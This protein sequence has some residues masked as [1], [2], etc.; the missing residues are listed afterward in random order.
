MKAQH[1]RSVISSAFAAA[2][3]GLV[4]GAPAPAQAQQADDANQVF[5]PDLFG[6][7]EYRM[8]GPFRGGRATAEHGFPDKP[9][10]YLMGSTGGGIWKTTDGG[11]HWVNISDGYFGGGIGEIT[12]APSDEQV[13]YVGTGSVSIRGNVSRGTGVY[14]S[15][16]G[17]RSWEHVG[18][19]DAGQVGR[20]A[21]HPK[22]P[23]VAYV[24][25]LGTP[26][27]KSEQRGVFK[28][29]DGGETWENVLF[30]N[31]STGVV[32]IAMNPERPG[33]VFAAAWPAERDPWTL[34]SG[35]SWNNGGGLYRTTDGGDSWTHLE[36]GLP[37][38]DVMIGKT[39]VTVS[40][41]DTD[42]VWAMI[43]ASDPHGGVYRSDDGG[44]SWTQT[45]SDH[46]LLQ[47]EFY[48]TYI[49]AHPTDPNTVYA[50]NTDM[51]ESVDGGGTFEEVDV[52]HGD[53]HGLWL[54]PKDPER[55]V[56]TNDGG[57]QIS[58]NGG[59]SWS[60]YHNQPTAEFY[61]VEVDSHW[62][63]NL[64]AG[65]QDNSTLRIPS[66]RKQG[67][68]RAQEW[69][70]VGGGESGHVAIQ[71]YGP[72]IVWAGSYGGVIT[73]KN[74]ETGHS[75]NRVAYPQVAVGVPEKEFR[76]RFQ[77]NAP[78][79]VNPHDS[80]EV[81]HAS[82]RLLRTQDGGM[83][84]E[85]ISPDLT[86]DDT[87][88]QGPAAD[89]TVRYDRTGVEIY[90]T[91]FVVTPSKQE[92]GVIWVGTDDGRV[93]LTRQGGGMGN[94]TEITPDGLPQWSTVNSIDVSPHDPSTAYVAAYR[95]RQD[96]FTPYVFKTED[97]GQS[98]TRIADGTR[99]IDPGHPTRVVREDTE[100]DGLLY[101]GTEYG[102]YVSFD[103][104]ANWQELQ[105]NL[106]E[107]PIT[108]L[109]V[110]RGDLVVATQGRSF[111]I[112]DD[113]SPL[114]QVSDQVVQSGVHLYQPSDAIRWLEVSAPGDGSTGP[115]QRPE[116]PPGG[117]VLDYY[118][119]EEATEDD[120][121]RLEV[122]DPDGNVVREYSTAAD[123]PAGAGGFFSSA[124]D[125]S[126]PGEAGHHR[127]TWS[128]RYPGVTEMPDDVQMWGFTG[129]YEA[130][131]GTYRARMIAGGDTT[132][133][134]FDVVKDPNLDNVSD[135]ELRE[136][137]QFARTVRD[138]L[139]SLFS[140]LKQVRGVREQVQ[141]TAEYASRSGGPES[142][143]ESA[144]ELVSVLTG[145]EEELIQPENESG[146]DAIHFPPKLDSQFAAVYGVVIGEDSP[147]TEGARERFQDLLPQWA[148]LRSRI[149]QVLEQQVSSYNDQLEQAGLQSVMVPGE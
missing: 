39:A 102:M 107:T 114:R 137:Q 10:T 149:Q 61:R 56:V 15:V 74:M 12:V 8:V 67:E 142:I 51:Y 9:D 116:T 4:I 83:S 88:K 122:V 105:L 16:D 130:A 53:V 104:G 91:I 23:E 36:G 6:D 19:P 124:L 100:R 143:Q 148:D 141:S 118:L 35:A 97:Y 50:L 75:P 108:D 90:N 52:P 11:H 66:I 134:S 96:D 20:I 49:H 133:R 1:L 5:Q 48:Y 32:D 115:N 135:E 3:C 98:W 127:V 109:E 62:P 63:Y 43:S 47:R 146:Q 81:Y 57:G 77:W 84:W 117:A 70:S 140:H 87:T 139:N 41:A 126:I 125:R 27:G 42:R 119:A 45:N 37:S 68:N 106:P 28:T 64:Y 18:L 103:D 24:A 55:M 86:Y 147:P 30:V 2:L 40:P 60:T 99:G 38:G 34:Q 59:E 82:Q 69:R 73:R 92:E 93:W 101:A 113:L 25:A 79:E 44:D 26:F 13:I 131:P 17:G 76:Y 72:D 7:M 46:K 65:Q 29:N 138:T 132:T 128:L 58:V 14:R 145:L 129:G 94:W 95:Y 111:W 112:L 21:V 121:V 33:E 78:I 31:D 123:A 120:P 89:P 110:H 54:N 22:D 144:D 80:T 136:Q 71:S 85:E